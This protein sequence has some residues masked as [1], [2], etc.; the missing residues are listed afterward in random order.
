M[1][2]VTV[3]ETCLAWLAGHI[4]SMPSGAP[5][6]DPYAVTWGL[7]TRGRLGEN[8]DKK[9]YACGV[10]D[11]TESKTQ[12]MG[13]TTCVLRVV[14][15]FR[16]WVDTGQDPGTETNMVLGELQRR[17]RE[18]I[19]CGDNALNL[20]ETGNEIDIDGPTDHQTQGAIFLNLQYRHHESDP[21]RRV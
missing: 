7:V 11:T 9:R 3:R 8:A 18:D 6:D 15:E 1:P 17:I 5:A 10:Y 16:V 4:A 2:G 20:V 12:A 14:I 21:R 19:T 13:K